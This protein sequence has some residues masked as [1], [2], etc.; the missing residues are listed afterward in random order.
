M[1]DIEVDFKDRSR[2]GYKTSELA[3]KIDQELN[4]RHRAGFKDRPRQKK[5]N[6]KQLLHT[7]LLQ[8][9]FVFIFLGCSFHCSMKHDYRYVDN[10]P[11]ED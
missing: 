3:S 6:W 11:E 1:Q 2:L 9:L 4:A 8:M 10:L 5:L 7:L